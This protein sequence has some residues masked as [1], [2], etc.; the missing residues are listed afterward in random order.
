[1][2]KR[3]GGEV[4][5][6]AK[7]VFYALVRVTISTTST[8]LY[9]LVD[10]WVWNIIW[11]D[12]NAGQYTFD[13]HTW[14][15]IIQNGAFLFS[16]KDDKVSFKFSCHYGHFRNF[17]WSLQSRVMKKTRA[18]FEKIIVM[19]I[20]VLFLF[21]LDLVPLQYDN[22]FIGQVGRNFYLMPFLNHDP[23]SKICILKE[24]GTIFDF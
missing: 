4:L 8:R 17:W 24:F 2:P 5:N 10:I 20:Y 13:K 15:R 19:G 22:I 16:M 9:D 21:S 11:D 18:I 6:K 23:K 3:G 12:G 7:L 1:M 14:V